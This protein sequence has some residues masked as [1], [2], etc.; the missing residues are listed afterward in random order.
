MDWN[1]SFQSRLF[2]GLIEFINH[3]FDQNFLILINF[4]LNNTK[5][6][7]NIF[8]KHDVSSD[9]YEQTKTQH[10]TMVYSNMC[11]RYKVFCSI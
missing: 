6:Q 3:N 4:R 9:G 8:V 1:Y 2:I 7:D 11:K 10:T 5:L